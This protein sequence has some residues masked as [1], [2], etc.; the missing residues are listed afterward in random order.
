M[1]AGEAGARLSVCPLGAFE[2]EEK[3]GGRECGFAGILR[4]L[5]QRSHEER[6]KQG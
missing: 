3:E 1:K 6:V 5:R 4:G 2:Q